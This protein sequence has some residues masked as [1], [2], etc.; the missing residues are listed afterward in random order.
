[1]DSGYMIGENDKE[2]G[3]YACL[4][5]EQCCVRVRGRGSFK[6]SS[7]LKTFL[8]RSVTERGTRT[9]RI[10]LRECIGMDSTFMGV[11]A[12]L[13]GRLAQKDVSLLLIN[14][15][16]KNVHLLKT[17]G[18]DKVLKYQTIEETSP[19]CTCEVT[20]STVDLS[21]PEEDRL[22][23][24]EIMLT[25]H[26]TLAELSEENVDRFKNVISFLE[27]DVRKLKE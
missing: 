5:G 16:K 3:L 13:S 15:D 24:A 19:A 22:G 7:N 1:M 27:Q 26:Q 11:L 9:V 2:D 17:L 20:G 12:G 4:D 23:T 18:I 14:L 8:E 21:E 6:V 25:A 10:D